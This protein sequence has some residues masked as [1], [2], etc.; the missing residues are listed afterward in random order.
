MTLRTSLLD[1]EKAL[2]QAN[3]A[4]PLTGRAGLRL[5][6]GLGAA[7]MAG[8]ADLHGRNANFGFGAKGRL[9]EGDFEVVAQVCTAIDVR[10][11]AATA[12]TAENLVEN[13]AKSVGETARAA[14]HA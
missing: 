11:T 5:R 12:S 7:T 3:L 10:T 4:T 9:L 13:T 8:S 6:A 1:R 14:A 2:L